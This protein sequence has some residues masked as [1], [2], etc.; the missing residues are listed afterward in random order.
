[1]RILVLLVLLMA[2]FAPDVLAQSGAMMFSQRSAPDVG[3]APYGIVAGDSVNRLAE[4]ELGS[5]E[6]LNCSSRG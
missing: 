5:I 2:L 4:A 3:S 1:M 6:A